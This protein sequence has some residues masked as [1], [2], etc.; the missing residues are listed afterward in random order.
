[1][2]AMFNRAR[3]ETFNLG[4]DSHMPLGSGNQL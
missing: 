3:E 1:M 2:A 4:Y